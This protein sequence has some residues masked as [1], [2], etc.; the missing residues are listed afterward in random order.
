MCHIEPH[1]PVATS[2]VSRWI[3]QGLELANI[4]T[5]I[6]SGHSTRSAS[7]TKAKLSGL[8]FSDILKGIPRCQ[9]MFGLYCLKWQENIYSS[10]LLTKR[11][12]CLKF[13]KFSSC[14][15]RHLFEMLILYFSKVRSRLLFV[16]PG[17]NVE[18][19][20]RQSR[21]VAS[22]AKNVYQPLSVRTRQEI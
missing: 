2:S 13:Y 10:S 20:Y 6:L 12:V 1:A 18:C 16:K 11:S 19:Q 7:S 5:S 3:K 17:C 21:E 14:F 15:L 4:N 22:K 9:H 8:S